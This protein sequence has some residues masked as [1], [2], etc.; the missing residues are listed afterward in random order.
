MACL[1]AMPQQTLEQYSLPMWRSR[2]PTHWMKQT[3]Y[4]ACPVDGRT[5]GP[6]FSIFS[7]SVSVMT[8]SYM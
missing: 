1:D 5:N 2:E 4:G 7:A 6:A 8:S 3:R